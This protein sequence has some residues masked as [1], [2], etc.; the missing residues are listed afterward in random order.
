MKTPSSAQTYKPKPLDTSQFH[1]NEDILRLTELLAENSHDV[2]AKQKIAQGWKWGP[3]H[4]EKLKEHPSLIPYTE[5]PDSDK[6]FD[7]SSALETIKMV[8]SLGLSRPDTSAGLSDAESI[9]TDPGEKSRKIISQLKKP[10]LTV[11]ELRRIWEERVPLVW[12]RNVEVYRR[13]VDAAMK[14]GEAFLAFDIAEEGLLTFKSDLRLIQLQ[15][16]ALARTGATKRAN[17]ILDGLRLSGHY[18]EETLGILARTHK[19]FWLLSSDAA[20]K[21]HHLKLSFEFYAESY[22]RNRGY[23]SG[24]NAAAMGLMY[25]QKEQARKWAEEVAQMCRTT[26]AGIANLNESDERYWLEATLAEAALILG[27]LDEAEQFYSHASEFGGQSWVVI[28]RTREQARLL[29]EHSG[30]SRKRL[31]HCFNLPRIAVCAGHMFDRVNRKNPR[32]PYAIEERVRKE[33]RERLDKMEAHVGFSSLACGADMLFA[34]AML[35]RGGEMN[36]VLPFNESD[37][38]A[39]S[40]DVVPGVDFTERFKKILQNAGT[41]TT[42][43]EQGSADDA[44]AFEYCNEV[45]VGLALLKAQFLGIDVMPIAIWDGK[46]GDGRGGTQS[47]VQAWLQRGVQTEIIDLRQVLAE[48]SNNVSIPSSIEV[49]EPVPAQPQ[50][51]K[52]SGHEVSAQETKAMLFADIKGY[53]KMS[54]RQIPAFVHHFLGRVASLMDAMKKPPIV[55]NTWGD[56]IYCVF[57][58]VA[59]AGV[60]ALNLRDMVH[61]T[62]WTQKGLPGDL[63]IRIALHGGPAYPCFDPVLRRITY[64]GSHVNRTA[65]IEPVAEEGQIYASQAFAALSAAHGVRDFSCDYVGLKQLAK[66]FG[67]L[68]VFLVRRRAR[69]F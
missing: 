16:L 13:A 65:R 48:E 7:R 36:I 45:L 1:L 20:E 29:L 27:R 61:S 60:F 32:F 47:F 18:D 49:E 11:A 46:P 24:I 40:V 50:L 44:A 26:Q 64:M 28:N 15:A 68:P 62:D 2:W 33:V 6:E 53:S 43:N 3:K 21:H 39:A 37:F 55:R 56:A 42:L 9:S 57:D 41:V 58:H 12:L 14:L 10:K 5:L 59:D 69:T 52:T 4:S 63:N 8:L 23:Y 54:E 31:D 19:D 17:E 51:L 67:S 38:R 66:D 35:E 25:G 34:E 22:R 30:E